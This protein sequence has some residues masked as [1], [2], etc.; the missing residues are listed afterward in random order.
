MRGADVK[1]L[2]AVKKILIGANQCHPPDKTGFFGH[3]RR[4][5]ASCPSVPNAL[6]NIRL[7]VS[8]SRGERLTVMLL[9]GRFVS[10][11]LRVV[12]ITH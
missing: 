1:G 3:H 4:G 12:D 9:Y 5:T 10:G 11:Y 8:G 2:F 6:N 7:K